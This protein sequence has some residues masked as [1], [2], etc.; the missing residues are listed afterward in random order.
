MGAPEEWI[1]K[2]GG[3]KN[4]KNTLPWPYMHTDQGPEKR[5]DTYKTG[6]IVRLFNQFSIECSAIFL[7]VAVEI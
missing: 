1:T 3:Q 7:H 4:A 2:R 5:C 6:P